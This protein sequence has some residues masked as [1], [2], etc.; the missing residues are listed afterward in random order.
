M[1]DVCS[2]QEVR[3]RGHGVR[4]LGMYGKR[5]KLWWSEKEMGLVV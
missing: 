5:Y 2:L 1:V 3:W 4:M